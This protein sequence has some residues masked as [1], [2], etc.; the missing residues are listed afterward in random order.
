M[1][2]I[3]LTIVFTIILYHLYIFL[4]ITLQYLRFRKNVKR[5]YWDINKENV[6]KY[7]NHLKEMSDLEKTLLDKIK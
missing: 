5:I 2:F 4:N 6:E 3:I 7:L 1:K